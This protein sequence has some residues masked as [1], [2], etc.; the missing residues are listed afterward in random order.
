VNFKD[1]ITYETLYKRY[2]EHI[3]YMTSPWKLFGKTSRMT[4]VTGAPM[5]FFEKATAGV[6]SLIPLKSWLN[7]PNTIRVISDS[8]E[9]SS[10]GYGA[11]TLLV[12][13]FDANMKELW[14]EINLDG[15]TGVTGSEVFR[16][17][18]KAEVIKVG[19][20]QYVN[21]GL[22]GAA[23]TILIQNPDFTHFASIQKFDTTTKSG[24]YIVPKDK[25]VYI[26]KITVSI[27]EIPVLRDVLTLE[28]ELWSTKEKEQRRSEKGAIIPHKIMSGTAL[29]TKPYEHTFLEPLKF[30]QFSFINFVV[31]SISASCSASVIAEGYEIITGGRELK[32]IYKKGLKYYKYDSSYA[33]SYNRRNIHSALYTEKGKKYRYN[34]NE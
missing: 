8:T 29:S 9:D 14:E 10:S 33:S 1:T 21:G 11:S 23:G 26:T 19:N 28:W 3:C 6:V 25:E 13:G 4:S 34:N 20:N 16:G 31:N 17:I 24:Y 32:D 27:E 22:W 2:G 18:N 15:T 12:T 30:G 7:H 5:M